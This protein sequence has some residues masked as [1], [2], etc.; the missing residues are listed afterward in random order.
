MIG[1]KDRIM[2]E[3]RVLVEFLVRVQVVL[4]YS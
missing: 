4:E 2:F 3:F 1:T